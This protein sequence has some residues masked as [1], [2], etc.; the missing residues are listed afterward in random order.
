MK[1]LLT[2]LLFFFAQQ[3]FAT[4]YYFSATGSDAG[5]GTQASPYQTITKLNS[6]T[7]SAGDSILFNRGDTFYGSLTISHS[8]S[9]GNPI[10]YGAYGTGSDPI[11]IGFTTVSSWTNLGSNIWEST[12]AVSSLSY[13][14]MVV[15]NGINTPMGRYPNTGYLTF[16]SHSG[17]T[18]IIS[19]SL[20]GTPN[21][22]GA[23]VVIRSSNWTLDRMAVTGQSVDT[24]TYGTF[25][26]GSSPTTITYAPTDGFGFFIQND[27]T[28]L[29]TLNEWYYNPTSKKLRIYSIVSPTGVQ[30]V[31]KSQLVLISANYITLNGLSFTGG[32]YLMESTS[33]ITNLTIQNCTLNY[34]GIDGALL[35]ACTNLVIDNNTISNSNNDGII[36]NSTTNG[37]LITNNIFNKNGSISGLG[38]NGVSQ[39]SGIWNSGKGLIAEHNKIL[40]TGYDGIASF[41]DSTLIKN[42]FID[43]FCTV[44]QDGGGTYT[45]GTHY[46]RKIQGNIVM[47]GIGVSQGTNSSLLLAEGIYCDYGSNDIDIFDNSVYNCVDAGFLLSSIN[48]INFNNNTSFNNKVQLKFLQSNTDTIRNNVINSNILISKL[49]SQYVI[50]YTNYLSFPI[51]SLGTL[52]SNYYARPIDD[53]ITFGSWSSVTGLESDYTLATWQSYTGQDVHSHKSPRTIS[54]TSDLLFEYNADSVVKT[55]SLPFWYMDVTGKIYMRSVTLQPYSSWVGIL[56]GYYDGKIRYFIIK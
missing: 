17:T 49:S 12:S 14:D 24:L 56:L 33:G 51:D 26:S 10:V 31:T 19:S 52:D 27:S 47:D 43:S 13:T 45:S 37:A 29:D 39:Y 15:I 2:I 22:T 1:K 42:N 34:A 28:A 7:P 53:N 36:L 40:N 21:W 3:L 16:Q 23:E 35:Y 25:A 6:L 38:Q 9:S 32:D 11:I 44:L 50:Y 54:D 30:V 5:A 18:Y 46:G 48:H 4:N 8:G 55:V 20:T 41:G